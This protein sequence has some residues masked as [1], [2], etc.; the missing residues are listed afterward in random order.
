MLHQA[1]YK[2]GFRRSRFFVVPVC[3]SILFV[4]C[5][6]GLAL[7]PNRTLSQY[8]HRI[9]QLPQGLP[10]ATI[11]SILQTHDGYLWLGTETG[12]VRFDGV[13]FSRMEDIPQSPL[14]RLWIRNLV[15][16]GRH[17]LWVGTNDA[18]L[19]HLEQGAVTQ[20][21][22]NDDFPHATVRGVWCRTV[23]KASGLA[24]PKG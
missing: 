7:D 20:Q 3:I 16:D 24:H 23:T 14:Y 9:W 1:S 5:T 21:A 4:W 6:P 22:P 13:R 11:T 10:D 17:N 12:L 8:V 18:G 19:F 2:A 15:E